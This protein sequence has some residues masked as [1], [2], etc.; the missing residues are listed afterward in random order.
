MTK[1]IYKTK[2]GITYCDDYLNV[3]DKIKSQSIDV[4]IT[5]PPFTLQRKKSYGNAIL[6]L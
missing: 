1:P 6:T 5:S 4:A 2:F 3:L